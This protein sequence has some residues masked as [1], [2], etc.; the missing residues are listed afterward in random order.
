MR[1]HLG[2]VGKLLT[3]PSMVL[4]EVLALICMS[5]GPKR[6]APVSRPA[7]HMMADIIRC[8]M[9]G[10]AMMISS[11]SQSPAA[12]LVVIV[13]AVRATAMSEVLS[14]P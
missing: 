12:I 14:F 9:N 6:V 1:G 7:T 2:D 5:A 3:W 10:R 13:A 4:T 8:S 11:G